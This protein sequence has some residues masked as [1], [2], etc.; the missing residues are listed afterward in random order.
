[1]KPLK[2]KWLDQNTD[3]DRN[4]LGYGF[5]PIALQP[6]AAPATAGQNDGRGYV[7]RLV[8]VFCKVL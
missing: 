6:S 3:T 5:K 8:I 4:F 1:M 2:I 7:F